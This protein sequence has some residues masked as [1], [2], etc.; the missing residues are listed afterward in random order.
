[1]ADF[2]TLFLA[3]TFNQRL[4]LLTSQDSITEFD[5]VSWSDR[6]GLPVDDGADSRWTGGWL[7]GAVTLANQKVVR[8]FKPGVDA[9]TVPMQYDP[10]DSSTWESKNY[11]A[12]VFRP[13][14]NYMMAGNVNWDGVEYPSRVQWCNAV[15]PGQVP[16]DWVPTD[17]N[18]AGDVDL[19]DT[20]GSIVDMHPLRD[21]LLIYK[22]D[23]IIACQWI[24][25]NDVFSFRTLT[26]TKGVYTRDCIVEHNGF[27]WVQGVEDIFVVD[28]NTTTSLIWGK[29]KRS[30]LKDRDE[31]RSAN[32]FTVLDPVNEE[33]LFGYVSKNAPAGY[34]Y[35]DKFLA[36]CLKN[37]I[38]TM[39]DYD[40]EMPYA[41]SSLDVVNQI[42]ANL[43]FYGIDRTSSRL[44]DLEAAP[45]RLGTPVPA[46]FTRTGLF[47]DPGHDWVQVDRV[48][49]QM[50]GEDA[51]LKLGNQSAIDAPMDW[52]D[53]FT[54]NPVTD[55]K[56]DA[57]AN[58]NL[59]AYR[60]DISTLTAWQAC[61]LMLL[62]QKGGSRG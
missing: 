9:A 45:D 41:L 12:N 36:L 34:T 4:L 27:H 35:P 13:F 50:T 43:V 21:A 28:G 46:Y 23:S 33:V 57:R 38:F 56:T 49:L 40:L 58:G 55:Y 60:V 2:N 39:R 15:E 1:M 19:A 10:A 62:V 25:G 47:S 29:N 44:L 31:S 59:I 8:T 3:K 7:T 18:R 30:W 37:N 26:R 48:K 53:D 5:G 52:R 11:S 24:G 20:P 17:T 16:D 61:N 51:T 22:S 32:N 42:S 14:R 6:T 54:I